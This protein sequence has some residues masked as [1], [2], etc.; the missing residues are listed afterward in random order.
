MKKIYQKNEFLIFIQVN[1]CGIYPLKAGIRKTDTGNYLAGS[2]M[3]VLNIIHFMVIQVIFVIQME[4]G[5]QLMEYLY[6]NLRT[7]HFVNVKKLFSFYFCV[8]NIKLFFFL[9][10]RLSHYS[11]KI[12][13][14][15]NWQLICNHNVCCMDIL[16]YRLFQES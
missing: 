7:G 6:T 1:S 10:I 12:L 3:T 11:I 4:H 2:K 5:Y 15:W 16:F 13:C 14:N 9:L 8:K